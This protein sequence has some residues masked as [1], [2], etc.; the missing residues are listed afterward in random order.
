M[1]K[2]GQTGGKRR[3]IELHSLGLVTVYSAHTIESKRAGHCVSV[4]GHAG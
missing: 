4:S 1:E 2:V 3:H